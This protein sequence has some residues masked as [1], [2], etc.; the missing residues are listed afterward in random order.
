ML[1][2]GFHPI[3]GKLGIAK[4]LR[5]MKIRLRRH[6]VFPRQKMRLCKVVAAFIKI[7]PA[8]P[9]FQCVRLVK[10]EYLYR[11]HQHQCP[12]D[13][14]IGVALLLQDASLIFYCFQQVYR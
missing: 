14:W 6:N 1:Y 7:N 2:S 12:I 13:G 5:P 4:K 3:S 8:A 11:Y 9:S 10:A